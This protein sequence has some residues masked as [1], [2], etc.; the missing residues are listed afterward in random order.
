MFDTGIILND[1]YW[2]HLCLRSASVSW[3]LYINGTQRY[4]KPVVVE[5][6]S[7]EGGTFIIGPVVM[8]IVQTD[9]GT[10]SID[11][12]YYCTN[13][14]NIVFHFKHLFSMIK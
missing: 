1:G 14:A 3:D 11:S 10:F 13:V 6:G 5:T 7:T 9:R 4:T 12:T 8:E 2:H